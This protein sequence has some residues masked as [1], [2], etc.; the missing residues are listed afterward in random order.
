VR[1]GLT[2]QYIVIGE[3]QVGEQVMKSYLQFEIPEDYEVIETYADL[4]YKGL[5]G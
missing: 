1:F 4:N 2:K 5:K 3:D